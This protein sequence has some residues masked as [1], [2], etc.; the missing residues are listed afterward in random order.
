MGIFDRYT[1]D[2]KRSIF[3]ARYEA[4]K[5]G[6]ERITPVDILL[7]VCRDENTRIARLT[8]I[9]QSWEQ[10]RSE[11]Y[12]RFP[13]QQELPKDKD[14]PLDNPSKRILAYAAE[15]A[16]KMKEWWLDSSFLILG[17]LREG[18]F[19]RDLLVKSGIT[20]EILRGQLKSDPEPRPAVPENASDSP[21]VTRGFAFKW[22]QGLIAAAIIA[23]SMIWFK[24]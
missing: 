6:S 9:R 16:V 22:W 20:D 19:A 5:R 10:Y 17:I 1:D 4:A 21:M 18:G 14:L 8:R 12:Q 13:P 15:E 24:C 11:I 7:G 3:F 23:L 2:A